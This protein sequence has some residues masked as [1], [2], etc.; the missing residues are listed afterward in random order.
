MTTK[1]L[2]FSS[3]QYMP[4]AVVSKKSLENQCYDVSI[5]SYEGESNGSYLKGLAKFRLEETKIW[6]MKYD[7]VVVV[8][9][10]CVFYRS[11]EDVLNL[12]GKCVLVPHVVHPHE[13]GKNFYP[14][15]HVNA[16]FM[17]FRKEGYIILDWLISQ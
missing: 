7:Q 11:I 8:G 14:T 17:I 6:L 3:M 4:Q 1:F 10:D 5:I 2:I 9:A 13:V 15:G 16:D 12:P